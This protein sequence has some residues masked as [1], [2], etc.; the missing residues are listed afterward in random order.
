MVLQ[1]FAEIGMWCRE[2]Q[3]PHFKGIPDWNVLAA[4]LLKCDI[5]YSESGMTSANC[6]NENVDKEE[7][8]KEH[9][10]D[11]HQLQDVS[12]PIEIRVD[13]S[14]RSSWAILVGTGF[15]QRRQHAVVKLLPPDH[16]GI[17][18]GLMWANVG[19][20][21]PTR[22]HEIN[23]A[24]L[25]NALMFQTHFTQEEWNKFCIEDLRFHTY[26]KS[27]ACYFKPA[28]AE[29]ADV[30]MPFQ[31]ISSE[32]HLC[33]RIPLG[34]EIDSLNTQGVLEW[35][36]DSNPKIVSGLK[37]K[38][39]GAIR[40]REGRQLS[41]LK[42][43]D[44]LGDKTLFT[45]EEFNDFQIRDLR[46]DDFVWSNC[47][48]FKPAVLDDFEESRASGDLKSQRKIRLRL[49]VDVCGIRS[50]E[51]RLDILYMNEFLQP[52]ILPI[53]ALEDSRKLPD[54]RKLSD[55]MLDIAFYLQRMYPN[56]TLMEKSRVFAWQKWAREKGISYEGDGYRPDLSFVFSVTAHDSEH[57]EQTL[58]NIIFI[59]CGGLCCQLSNAISAVSNKHDNK[60]TAV[61]PGD[62]T[63][64]ALQKAKNIFYH[65]QKV[66]RW[67]LDEEQPLL[68][69]V[70]CCKH[71]CKDEH[72]TTVESYVMSYVEDTSQMDHSQAVHKSTGFSEAVLN[73]LLTHHYTPTDDPQ[74]RG[75]FGCVQRFRDNQSGSTVVIKLIV[76]RTL[77]AKKLKDCCAEEHYTLT[78]FDSEFIV[79]P[80]KLFQD[81]SCI[82]ME[83]LGSMSLNDRLNSHDKFPEAEA[84]KVFM[85]VLLGLEHMH[86][87]GW[88]HNDVTPKNIMLQQN[89][90]T[91]GFPYTAVIV[92]LGLAKERAVAEETDCGGTL[93]YASPAYLVGRPGDD[94]SLGEP[95]TDKSDIFMFG[96][97]FLKWHKDVFFSKWCT[98]SKSSRIKEFAATM[99][100]S[101]IKK[102]ISRKLE[103][104]SEHLYSDLIEVTEGIIDQAC[105]EVNTL[106]D[107]YPDPETALNTNLDQKIMRLSS[108]YDVLEKELITKFWVSTR[109]ANSPLKIRRER[110][111]EKLI[112]KL[113]RC[114]ARSDMTKNSAV[115]ALTD[116]KEAPVRRPAS[117]DLLEHI[118]QCLHLKAQE[119][120]SALLLLKNLKLQA[121]STS[122][123]S[124]QTASSSTY[125]SESTMESAQRSY[126]T[127]VSSSESREVARPQGESVSVER[128]DVSIE[129]DGISER[130]DTSI[131]DDGKSSESSRC[132]LT[133]SLC[134]RV[135]SVC[136][137]MY[138]L[139]D[140]LLQS[141]HHY[142][143]SRRFLTTV[144]VFTGCD[145]CK[146]RTADARKAPWDNKY[147]PC[148]IIPHSH[149]CIPGLPS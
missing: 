126:G 137:V 134:A 6:D 40:P 93:Q 2:G 42:L 83:D 84:L 78:Q 122:R 89:R 26:I 98:E 37:W 30:T 33:I 110:A 47:S 82:V 66:V 80:K 132:L 142:F 19:T 72:S 92:D 10:Q 133:C 22:G 14:K 114:L 111:E 139:S 51:I 67:Y 7:V 56:Q 149:R 59:S 21:K 69:F 96:L 136:C 68:D 127:K 38:D 128:T 106:F 4:M 123:I 54:G 97:T 81:C 75:G 43:E 44:A 5:S 41:N 3:S 146:D 45:Q 11:V 60:F 95:F 112:K 9:A 85:D 99:L 55:I 116:N 50:N 63:E 31:V 58:R 39:I 100:K 62:G 104:P 79:K 27:D 94:G 17:A 36:P 119:R 52:D 131:E 18:S 121:D 29:T 124:Q 141:L 16:D 53:L 143:H 130:T 23:N 147:S 77:K 24:Q 57:E 117:R 118:K 65:L 103:K 145:H 148:M 61:G 70:D 12:N 87:R 73:T 32:H 135:H 71:I 120:P 1:V 46:H 49:C 90:N 13:S 74:K 76:S 107:K 144:A 140:G 129:D 48:Y 64:M 34:R 113:V 15:V 28:R 102:K 138:I 20:T 105:Q 101:C 88:V 8:M 35:E 109:A 108:E 115:R 86:D 25:S 125:S 91:S